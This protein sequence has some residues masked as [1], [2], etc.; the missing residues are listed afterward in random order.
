M[1]DLGTVGGAASL[2]KAVNDA[3]QIF[4]QSELR[5]V[6]LYACYWE[7]ATSKC[8]RLPTTGFSDISNSGA[9]VGHLYASGVDHMV[10]WRQGGRV[11]RL[12]PLRAEHTQLARINDVNQVTFSEFHYGRFWRWRARLSSKPPFPDVRTYL[13]DPH[14]GRI[15]LDTVVPCGRGEVFTAMD[16]NVHGAI[17]GVIASPATKRYRGVLLEPIPE[18]WKK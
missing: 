12:F 1:R 14:K 11:E 6:S 9:V 2:A 18:R 4:G 3:G 17:V 13:W 7:S 5:K 8:V 10:L 15:H 16:L